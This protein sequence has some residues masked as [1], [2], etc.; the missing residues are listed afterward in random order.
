MIPA[1]QCKNG[2]ANDVTFNFSPV[3]LPEKVVYE[4]SYNTNTAGLDPKGVASLSDSLNVALTVEPSTG[5]STDT[6]I[7]I[8]GKSNAD[9]GNYTPAVQFKAGSAN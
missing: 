8:D 3:T 2:I 7:W 6:N 9:F 5:S 1:K 4:I